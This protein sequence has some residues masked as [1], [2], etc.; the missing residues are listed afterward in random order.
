MLSMVVQVLVDDFFYI[1]IRNE[2]LI[3]PNCEIEMLALYC[4]IY[5]KSYFMDI[6]I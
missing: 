5:K 4:L 1:K 6:T 3:T 2:D